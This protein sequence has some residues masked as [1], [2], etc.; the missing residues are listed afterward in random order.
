MQAAKWLS[1]SLSVVAL[2]CAVTSPTN[3]SASVATSASMDTMNGKAVPTSY[4]DGKTSGLMSVLPPAPKAGDA[5]DE[6]DRRIF[7]ETRKYENTAR[8]QMASDD[9]DLSSARLFHHFSCSL[10]IELTPQ[11]ALKILQITQKATRDAA[12][13]MGKA[14]DLYQ[15]KRPFLVDDGAICRPRKEVEGIFDYPSGHATAGWS[16]ALVLSQVD[17]DHAAAILARGRSIGDS[18][19]FCGVHNLSAVVEARVLTGAALSMV[20][21]TQ[22]YQAELQA[23]QLE[24]AALRNQPHRKPDVARCEAEAKLVAMPVE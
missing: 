3:K 19:V 9:A 23:A 22:A 12:V 5:R 13:P 24:L 21:N 4:L 10:G 20:M 11:K 1:V 18:R 15:R 8:W 17:P 2:G 16:W 14:K 7:R 6:A